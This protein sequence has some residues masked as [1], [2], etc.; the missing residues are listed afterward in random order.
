MARKGLGKM[1]PVMK[2]WL[3]TEKGYVFGE[4]TFGLLDRIE[5][6]GTI[7]KAASSMNMSY[8]QAWGILKKIERRLG[9]PLVETSRGGAHGGGRTTLTP[10]GREALRQYLVEREAVQRAKEDRERWG[11][12][13]V[14]MG[15]GNMLNAEVVAVEKG[16]VAAV[17]KV[18]IPTP[19]VMTAIIPMETMEELDLKEG[20][21]VKVVV[22]ATSIIIGR[23]EQ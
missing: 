7:S 19:T 20:V 8:R 3:E 6:F 13:S 18:R 11:N 2:L 17:V 23:T 9:E 12:L 5:R 14:A 4:G 21:D 15:A 1:K 16:D 22:K 10:L